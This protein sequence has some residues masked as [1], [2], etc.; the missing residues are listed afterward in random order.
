[1]KNKILVLLFL[2][3][4]EMASCQQPDNIKKIR[5]E[6]FKKYVSCFQIGKLPLS[7][8]DDMKITYHD[9]EL[10]QIRRFI[11]KNDSCLKDW[12]GYDIPFASYLLLPSNGNYVILIHDEST[13]GGTVRRLSTYD[14]SG[15]KISELEIFAVKPFHGERQKNEIDHFEIESIISNDLRIEKKYFAK[16]AEEW[17]ANDIR[18]FYGRYIESI[19]KIDTSGNITLISEKDHGKQKYIGGRLDSIIFPRWKLAQ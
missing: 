2:F 9:F 12:S 14:Y 6:D 16:Y 3:A 17:K 18:Y 15:L 10:S 11:C 7:T 5:D 4:T 13:E 1:M 8:Y 19:F